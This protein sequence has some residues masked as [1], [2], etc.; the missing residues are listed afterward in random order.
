MLNAI[1]RFFSKN[2]NPASEAITSKEATGH[3]LQL[4][5][6]AL[7]L[8]AVRADATEHPEERAEVETAITRAFSL[9]DAET[10]ELIALAEAETAE[11]TSLYQFTH[12]IDKGYDYDKK[13]QVVEM[14]WQVV[15][16]D[17]HMEKYEEHLVRRVADLIHVAHKDFINLKLKV[18]DAP[19]T[20]GGE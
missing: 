9:S 15:F 16:A 17:N 11:A 2:L 8:E 5:T 10:A 19:G 4:A 1:Q 3:A 12:L 20:P 7:L 14:L 6:A 18:R 13:C